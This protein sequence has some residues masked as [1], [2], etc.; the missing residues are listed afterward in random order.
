VA[1]E[2]RNL[3]QRSGDAAHEIEEITQKSVEKVKEGILMVTKTGQELKEIGQSSGESAS[4]IIEIST[5]TE[6][7]RISMTQ[8]NQAVSSLDAMTQQ[9]AALVEKTASSS[10]QMAQQ[11]KALLQML[12]RFKTK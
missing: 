7:Q 6:E 2:V 1:G 11:A 12:E 10:K 4:L 5:S 8:I 9:N 3:A